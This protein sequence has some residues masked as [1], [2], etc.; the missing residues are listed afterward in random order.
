MKKIINLWRWYTIDKKQYRLCM[1]KLFSGNLSSL[2]KANMVVFILS[3][4]FAIINI[5]IDTIINGSVRKWGGHLTTAFVSLLLFILLNYILNQT[6]AGKQVHIPLI[7]VLTTAYYANITWFGIYLGVWANPSSH[8]VTFMC[9]LICALFLFI[10]PPAFNLCLTLGAMAIFVISTF[11]AKT[12]ENWI[13]DIVNVMGA[14]CISLFF[15]WQIT[16]F[17]IVSSL[18]VIKLENE[19]NRYYDEST[20][21]ELTQLRNRRDFMQTFQRYLSNY[22]SSDDWLCIAIVDIDFFKNYN[23][24]YGHQKG[25]ECLRAIGGV[26]N[27][28]RDSIGVYAA[29]VGGEEFALLWF[30]KDTAHVDTVVSHLVREIDELKIPHER[31]SAAPNITLSVGI[32]IEQCGSPNGIKELYDM[33]DKALYTAKNS[34]RNCTIICGEGFDQYRIPP[35]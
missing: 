33:A 12:Q 10:F 27:G 23:D 34:G 29:R 8:A 31:S 35:A 9:I 17:R 19:R 16:K 4:C 28:L 11:L 20:I 6:K 26:L 30:E 2:R 13:V 5:I 18:N 3:G 32:R 14:G 25:D 1:Q 22:R 21:D 7:Y 15:G 24:F